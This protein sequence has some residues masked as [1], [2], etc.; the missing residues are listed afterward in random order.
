MLGQWMKLKDTFRTLQPRLYFTIF[1]CLVETKRLTLVQYSGRVQPTAAA[2]Q[3][4]I[5]RQIL[6]PELFLCKIAGQDLILR[7]ISREDLLL[8]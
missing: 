4:L 3:H 8:R 5:L 1:L 2:K 6:G 7:H